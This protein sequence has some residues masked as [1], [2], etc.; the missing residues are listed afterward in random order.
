MYCKLFVLGF[1]A[2]ISCNW[3][4]SPWFW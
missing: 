2:Y 3:S 1:R 4:K